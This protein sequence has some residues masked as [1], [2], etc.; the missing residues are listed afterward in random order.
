MNSFNFEKFVD[1]IKA[2]VQQLYEDCPK[3]F[4]SKT[5]PTECELI[6]VEA[7]RIVIDKS[8]ISC[9]IDYSEGGHA[10]PDIVYIMNSGEKYGIEVK[11]STS[12]NSSENNWTILGNSILGSTRIDVLDVHIVFIKINKKGVFVNSGRYSDCVSDVVVTH[13]PRYKI[14]LCQDPTES[15]F[16]ESG[17]SYDDMKSSDNPIGLVTEY[18]RNKGETAWWLSESTSAT[19]SDWSDLSSEEQHLVY[20][21]AFVLFPE[22]LSKRSTK[23]KR[24]A[25]WLVATYSVVDSSLR[26]RF[27][28]GG[29]VNITINETVY[30]NIPKVFQVFQQ[31]LSYFSQ[32]VSMLEFDVLKQYWNGYAPIFD[33]TEERLSYWTNT[34]ISII[35]HQNH[36][37]ILDLISEIHLP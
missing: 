36:T 22:L 25:K 24:F 2:T 37:C 1:D 18:F 6:V 33:N 15:F 34:V 31:N 4:T 14:D 20:G 35:D 8:G 16:Y 7:S 19:I 28:A 9:T 21:N 29:K 3:R 10:F 26:D 32:A 12:A 17:I 5:T 30:T 13:S 23:Y 27:T 11:S